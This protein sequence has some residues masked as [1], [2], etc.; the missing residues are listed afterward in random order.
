M[1][2]PSDTRRGLSEFWNSSDESR[3]ESPTVVFAV[4]GTSTPT[5]ERPGIGASIRTGCAASAS[6]KLFCKLSIFE[7]RTPSAG[8]RA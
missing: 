3:V 7:S 6:S 8:L 5:S 4:F 2:L 1:S